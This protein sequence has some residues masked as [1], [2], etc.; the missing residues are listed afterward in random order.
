MSTLPH[1][2]RSSLPQLRHMSDPFPYMIEIAREY[3]DRVTVPILG[4]GPLVTLADPEGIRALFS[5][6]SST[7]GMATNEALAV[8]LGRGSIFLQQGAEHRRTRK[9]L[10]PAFHGERVRNYGAIMQ[11]CALRWT[12][13]FATNKPSPI[14]PTAQGITLDVIIEAIFGEQDRERVR[15]LHEGI[16]AVVEAFNPMIATFK[17][18]QREFFGVGPW[19]RFRRKAEA[20]EALMLALIAQKRGA[21]G[22]DVL[23]LLVNAK[24]EE[25]DS[26]GDREILEQLLTFV[27]AG[28]E[29]TA[30]SLAWAVYELH[31]NGEALA[32]LQDE[33]DRARGDQPVAS[34]EALVK[35][36]YLRAACDEVLRLHPP[37]PMIQR[38][39]V[40]PLTV[41]ELELPA[42]TL[43][44]ANA[45]GAHIREAVF[46]EP[47]A[48]R[49][50]RFIERQF[51]PFE[52]LPWGGGFRRC[53]GA[54]FAGYELQVVLGTMLSV[55]RFE[56]REPKPVAHAFRIGT[57]G[58]A[59]GVR[60]LRTR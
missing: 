51:S 37:V 44:A 33:L 41:G 22:D 29:T 53:L 24:D 14:L 9:L 20:L 16:L 25:G 60:V 49:P 4:V 6:D 2:P 56:L 42:G 47:F 59:T 21:G 55:A 31:R 50:E 45:Y 3:G 57:Y 39:L 40:A 35:L 8:I 23:S 10:M 5:A 12:E 26:L 54:A 19:A 36:P 13:T 18:L 1:G 43:V 30:T 34:P 58:P 38:K 48:F 52:Y 11:R 17:A 7:F 46:A 28:H 15:A 27:V 32:K